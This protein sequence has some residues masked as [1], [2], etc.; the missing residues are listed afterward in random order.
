MGEDFQSSKE[1]TR[2]RTIIAGIGVGIIIL[3]VV[4]F[5]MFGGYE[6]SNPHAPIAR[7][8]EKNGPVLI[9]TRDGNLPYQ[10]E[11]PIQPAYILRTKEGGRMTVEYLDDATRMEI[12]PVSFIQID[13]N[14]EGKRLEVQGG[15]IR[16]TVAPQPT[17]N[18]MRLDTA[19]SE[20]LVIEPGSFRV[21]YVDLKARYEVEE[22]KLRVRRLSDGNTTV[23]EAGQTHVCKPKGTGKIEFGNI[24]TSFGD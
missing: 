15:G 16:I 21:D 20:A 12:M 24:D 22:G 7:I 4:G 2:H 8:A 23:V 17:D 13:S 5:R 10:P 19:I 3:G 11:M 14:A 1:R 18:P 6:A 9:D